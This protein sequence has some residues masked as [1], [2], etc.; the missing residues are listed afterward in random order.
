MADAVS[1]FIQPAWRKLAEARRTDIRE[2]R[3]CLFGLF[4]GGNYGNDGSLE[5]MLLF[6]RDARPDAEVSC[7]CVDPILVRRLH[8]IPTV[9]VS[10][11]GFSNPLLR[12]LDKIA[13]KVPGRLINW[14]RAIRHLRG[15]DV[16]LVPGT[17]TLC[18]YRSGPFGT[19]YGL[20]RWAVAAKLCGTKLCFVSTGA[21][22]IN[23][24]LSRWMIKSAASIAHYRSFRDQVSKDFVASLGIDTSRDPVYPD[25]V[26]RL[27]TPEFPTNKTSA[28]RPVTFGVGVMNY[29]GWVPRQDLVIYETYLTK[30]VVFV[31][32]LLDHGH[33]VRLLVG[34]NADEKMVE[35]LGRILVEKGYQQPTTRAPSVAEPGQVIAEPI[36]SL[37][38]IMR[39]ITDTDIVIATRFHNIICSLKLARPTISIGYEAK[40][41]AIMTD[42]GL[43]NF[44]QNI[45]SL[46]VDRLKEQTTELLKWT[47]FYE[48]QTRRGLENVQ[49]RMRQQEEFLM[50][51]IL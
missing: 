49:G 36:N 16:L 51:S 24:S 4:G 40:N 29:N 43:R 32:W 7:V 39:Q 23:R 8:K 9:A 41:E 30:M 26:F 50:S 28:G 3:I 12:R 14:I 21:G 46:D 31:A 34:E 47:S 22:P 20:F 45:E 35:D 13:M 18:D 27:S 48:Q 25:L 5:S 19:P 38:D 1:S 15:F 10:W 42:I 6:L 33:R 2:K 17:S 11:P 44:C 37:H